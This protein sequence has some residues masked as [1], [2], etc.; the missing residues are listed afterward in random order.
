MSANDK[1][2]G[3]DHY[4]AMGD[5]QPWNVLKA[6]LT[7]EEYRG[8]QKGVVIAYLAR[9][10]AKGGDQD[11]AKAAH[12]LSKLVEDLLP[13][14]PAA[15]RKTA[16][17]REQAQVPTQ[18]RSCV[19]C[20]HF[21]G[22]FRGGVCAR[23]VFHPSDDIACARSGFRFWEPREAAMP[24]LPQIDPPR[25]CLTCARAD[26]HAGCVGCNKHSLWEKA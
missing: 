21:R 16:A 8:Y 23:P 24:P 7:P 4:R 15:P 11:I 1:Q 22:D 14:E 6:W 17:E 20:E 3:G 26:M 13:A 18:E 10:K 19:S 25:I 5:F 9:E 12:H 2:V